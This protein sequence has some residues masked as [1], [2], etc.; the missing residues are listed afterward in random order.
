MS[1]VSGVPAAA[2][3]ATVVAILAAYSVAAMPAAQ[4]VPDRY[5][6]VL[7]DDVLDPRRVA[8][9]MAQQYGLAVSHVYEHALKGFAARIPPERLAAVRADPRVLFVSEDREVQT[10]GEPAPAPTRQSG[11]DTDTAGELGPSPPGVQVT[12]R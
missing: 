3:A 5:V 9:A 12:P 6:V 1:A 11:A 7:R 4:P 2:L 10:F 8:S